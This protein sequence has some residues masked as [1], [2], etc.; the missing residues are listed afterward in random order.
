[1]GNSNDEYRTIDPFDRAIGALHGIPDVERV[2]ATTIRDVSTLIG[3]RTFIVQ[4]YR[5][6]E[7]G[8]TVFIEQT[9]A[10]GTIRIALPPQVSAAIAR[11]RDA[12]GGK[13]RSKSAKL[14]AEDRKRRGI[15]PGF[16]RAKKGK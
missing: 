15:V 10:E 12:I 3:S 1:M 14:V 8:D 2:K 9:S 6:R 5:H 11:Q 7:L 4:T 13:V 16:M